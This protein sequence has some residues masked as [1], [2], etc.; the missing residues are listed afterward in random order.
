MTTT[1]ALS[2]PL[3]PPA[4]VDELRRRC[5]A[6]GGAYVVVGGLAAGAALL[7]RWDVTASLTI[8]AAILLVAATWAA[9]RACTAARRGVG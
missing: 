4:D 9:D 3:N 2:G 7:G 5:Y 1:D 8:A 6:L